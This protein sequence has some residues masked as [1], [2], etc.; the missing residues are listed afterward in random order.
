M[1]HGC[2]SRAGVE[3]DEPSADTAVATAASKSESSRAWRR[4]GL[5][6][7][8][9]AAA[10]VL[11]ASGILLG[12]WIGRAPGPGAVV[13]GQVLIDGVAVFHVPDD[14]L[15]E[16][17]GD[18][19]AVIRLP[20]GSHAALAP[21]SAVVL[22]QQSTGRRKL[23]ELDRGSGTFHVEKGWK[24]FRVYTRL[25]SV[26]TRDAE[27]RIELKPDEE[28]GE[29]PVNRR[30]AVLMIVAALVGQVE[31]ESGGQHYTL[32][33]GQK[34]S[35]ADKSNPGKSKPAFSGA[36][37]E[38]SSNSLTVTAPPAKKGGQPTSKQFKF[39]DQTKFN[40][41]GVAKDA[42]KPT[43]G[44]RA[45]VW[46]VEGSEDT[47]ARV[48][49]GLKQTILDG[50]IATVADDGKS[51]T[52]KRK[53]KGGKE[54]SVSIKIADGAKVVYRDAGKGDKPM[55]G[56]FFRAW[57]K[58]GSSDTASG[59]VFSSKAIDSP[60]GKKTAKKP[61]LG[62]TVKAV[63]EG[64]NGFTL[65]TPPKKKGDQPTT[66]DLKLGEAA[67]IMSGKEAEQ[68][69][70]WPVGVRVAG[71]WLDQ[72]DQ[73]GRDRHEEAHGGRQTGP[74]RRHQVG[75]RGRQTIHPRNASEKEGRR[76]DHDRP[77]GRREGEDHLR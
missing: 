22:R 25:G 14:S 6:W 7:K 38:V 65:E 19:D 26:S 32:A 28:E 56:Y 66:I 77:E 48:Q 35:F 68:A 64:G 54:L 1:C 11:L 61:Y 63:S 60:S 20:D 58:P 69:R 13:S 50:V 16:I 23:V 10:V 52:F 21:N 8:W 72:R 57:M 36:I 30:S 44:Y 17:G 40:Y 59:I 74:D 73:G 45:S 27:F 49:L 2:V 75:G 29:E 4:R 70:R 53:V 41:F 9:C 34:K 46:L 33:A 47:L 24:Q 15:I 31:V 51:F 42:E 18:V 71:R 3:G 5:P 76:T 55:A 37:T 67:K 62:G 39:T 43:V 12:F